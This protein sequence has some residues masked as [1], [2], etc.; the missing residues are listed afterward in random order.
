[1]KYHTQ[2]SLNLPQGNTEPRKAQTGKCIYT[3][4]SL[5]QHQCLSAAI[6]E[7]KEQI[8]YDIL[9]KDWQRIITMNKYET[10]QIQTIT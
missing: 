5:L 2:Y 3:D 7:K 9:V 8:G 10:N 4:F 6:I 1:M